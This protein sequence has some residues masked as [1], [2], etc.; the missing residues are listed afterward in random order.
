MVTIT[1]MYIAPNGKVSNVWD[2][3]G[4]IGIHGGE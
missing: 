1:W 4:G 2:N 3:H